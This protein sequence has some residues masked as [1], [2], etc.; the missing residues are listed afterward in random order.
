MVVV[1]GQFPGPLIQANWGDWIEVTVHNQIYGPEEPT[2]LHHHGLNQ[3]GTPWADGV[4]SVSQCPIV[5]GGN[6]TYRFRAD[7]FGSSWWHSHYSAQ[8]SSGVVGPIVIHGPNDVGY[9]VDMYPILI[10]DWNNHYYD[11]IV[12][13]QMAPSTNGLPFRPFS[14]SNLVG[15]QGTYPCANVTNGA[16][17]TG[18][19]LA[20]WEF[21]AGKTY[22]LRFINVGSES[23]E[24]VSIDGHTMTVIANDFVPVQPY[25]V[26][27]LTLAVGQRVDVV[28]K[29]DQK[30]GAYYLRAYNQWCSDTLNPFGAGIIRYKGTSS[31]AMPSA[32][33]DIPAPIN[34]FCANDPLNSTVPQY[35]IPAATPDITIPIDISFG[36]DATGKFVFGHNNSTYI[37]D[38]NNSVLLDTANG[39]NA[40]PP[41]YNVINTG[42]A[43]TVR[44]IL[45]TSV[46]PAHPWHLHGHDFQ[47]LAEGFGQWDGTITNPQNPQRRDVQMMWIGGSPT[48][49]A[50][51]VIQFTQDNPGVWPLHCHIAAHLTLGMVS[52][53][54]ERPDDVKGM[55]IPAD[56]KGT[57]PAFQ[58]WTLANP[59]V[60]VDE[61]LRRRDVK[62]TEVKGVR[63][64][65][66]NA[67]VIS[68]PVK[69]RFP[70]R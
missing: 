30:P 46:G 32:A 42:S 26:T 19:S 35:A 39:I 45:T 14:D 64:W 7:T 25:A 44:I 22:R 54:L 12:A 6:L 60:E 10:S 5:P 52:L 43:Q 4:P 36:P 48:M 17:C 56:V 24:T 27:A 29:A 63:G 1:N 20:S 18:G 66:N 61:T 38:M 50:Y 23:M 67:E 57:C 55:D 68:I 70:W 2:S 8:Y 28:V 59:G 15:G 49:P 41:H 51:T 65:G 69:E 37:P 21:E 3:P 58:T 34:Q 62:M 40:F 53:I 9:D 33:L 11:E 16:P 13:A 47:V 31:S